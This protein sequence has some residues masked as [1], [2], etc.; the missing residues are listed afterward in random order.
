M[1]MVATLV[2][3]TVAVRYEYA[4]AVCPPRV[5]HD[6]CAKIVVSEHDPKCGGP[7]PR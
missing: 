7:R 4:F 3:A 2:L 5:V 1:I 6:P